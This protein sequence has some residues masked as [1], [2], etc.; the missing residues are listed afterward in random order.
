MTLPNAQC[1]AGDKST[2]LKSLVHPTVYVDVDEAQE[3]ATLMD[4]QASPVTS[5]L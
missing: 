1:G 5:T 2:L 3:V 4:R